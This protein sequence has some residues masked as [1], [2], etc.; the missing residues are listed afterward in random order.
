[1]VKKSKTENQK[2]L[3]A[4]TSDVDESRLK[5]LI[6]MRFVE[7]V[8]EEDLL[9]EVKSPLER[10]FFSAISL[11]DLN[12]LEMIESLECQDPVVFRRVLECRERIKKILS[13]FANENLARRNE[14]SLFAHGNFVL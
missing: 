4:N 3:T 13:D 14:A 7:G 2:G 9:K 5:E 8:S 11:R 6:F 12:R 10:E 1:M